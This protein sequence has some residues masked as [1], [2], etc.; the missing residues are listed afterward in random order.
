MGEYR[1][2]A[3][4]RIEADCEYSVYWQS[5]DGNYHMDKVIAND[6]DDALNQT[7]KKPE[8]SE[9]LLVLKGEALI[10]WQA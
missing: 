9:T 10:L 5:N 6:H 4:A 8:C 7:R 2:M 3:Q 1:N